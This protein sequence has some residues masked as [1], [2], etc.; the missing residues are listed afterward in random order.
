MRAL[1]YDIDYNFNGHC[2]IHFKKI[3]NYKLYVI[4]V[5][6]RVLEVKRLNKNAWIPVREHQGWLA[7][8]NCSSVYSTF[9][10]W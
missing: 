3:R 7:M 2:N 5:N 8:T 6:K 10:T 9:D 4:Q 1:M